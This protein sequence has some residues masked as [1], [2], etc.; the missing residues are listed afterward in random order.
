MIFHDSKLNDCCDK[1][2]KGECKRLRL[3][4]RHAE[5]VSKK[6]WTMSLVE[7]IS[8]MKQIL[9]STRDD[10]ELFNEGCAGNND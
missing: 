4:V 6:N 3:E 1:V 10:V 8:E 7:K 9:K 2:L 5:I